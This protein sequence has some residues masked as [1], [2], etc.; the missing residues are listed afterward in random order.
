M[1]RLYM[2]YYYWTGVDNLG[3][4]V[5]GSFTA[6]TPE[7]VRCYLQGRSIE[8]LTCKKQRIYVLPAMH[9]YARFFEHWAIL[10][11]AG[12]GAVQALALAA[13]SVNSYVLKRS[14]HEVVAVV[15]EGTAL[16]E[17]LAIQGYFDDIV[18]VLVQSG[19]ETGQLAQVVATLARYYMLQADYRRRIKQALLTPIVTIVFFVAI[20]IGLLV[21]VVP[22]FEHMM[23]MMHIEQLETTQWLFWL[24]R[25]ITD[26]F[27]WLF[28]VCTIVLW[29]GIVHFFKKSLRHMYDTCVLHVPLY[30]FLY[31]I[32][33][34]GTMWDTFGLLLDAGIQPVCACDLVA[35]LSSNSVLQKAWMDYAHDISQGMSFAQAL[36]NN[37]IL[38]SPELEA[39]LQAGQASGSVSALIQVYATRMQKESEQKLSALVV[40]I[41]PCIVIFLGMAL[42]F[43]IASVYIPLLTLSISFGG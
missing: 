23:Q 15:R 26:T 31:S 10:L 2:P 21:G 7:H 11:R 27:F 6:R 43:I 18:V 19:Q 36:S 32:T 34:R 13:E 1:G 9:E 29:Y 3:E 39:L 24:S 30:G 35:S 38:Y 16:S 12:I 5:A 28:V 22:R 37:H 40:L 20:V 4:F 41:Q 33:T 8:L 14:L 17:A 25:S 42:A